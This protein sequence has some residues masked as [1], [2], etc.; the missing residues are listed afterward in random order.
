MNEIELLREQLATERRRV[1]EVASACAAAHGS[2]P[3][4]PGDGALEALRGACAEYL[5]CVLDWFDRRDARLGELYARRPPVDAGPGALAALDLAGRGREALEEL[6]TRGSARESWQALARFIRG[7]WDARR[8]A[9]EALLASNQRV[10]DW[11]AITGVD[12]DSVCHERALF[13][14]VV[15]VLPAGSAPGPA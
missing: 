3:A 12:A 1:R 2:A 6:K 10:A 15:A 4:S 13:A 9:I 8:D 7:P 5:G 11:R 14:R